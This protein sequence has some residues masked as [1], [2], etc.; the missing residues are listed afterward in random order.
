M[1]VT[2]I[3]LNTDTSPEGVFLVN[4]KFICFGPLEG[5]V[6]R[7]S[8]TFGSNQSASLP[9]CRR[10]SEKGW[11]IFFSPLKKLV[12]V[13]DYPSF[14]SKVGGQWSTQTIT[15]I[16]K[17]PDSS[18]NGFLQACLNVKK[19]HEYLVPEK[20]IVI[21]FYPQVEKCISTLRIVTGRMRSWTSGKQGWMRILWPST[22]KY[23]AGIIANSLDVLTDIH[24]VEK[25]IKSYRDFVVQ[26][27]MVF[28]QNIK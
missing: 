25:D 3:S 2:L 13:T 20:T 15:S 10:S 11:R 23:S 6:P 17:H 28:F 26:P 19:I 27:L 5:K 9:R 12:R 4:K 18:I 21:N 14:L 22:N 7:K 24:G 8:F 16:R 1:A